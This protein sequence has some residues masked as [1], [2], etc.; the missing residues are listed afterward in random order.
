MHMNGMDGAIH[1]R[2]Q[3]I[4]TIVCKM[5]TEFTENQQKKRQLMHVSIHF[6]YANIEINSWWR[7]FSCWVP[8]SLLARKNC[9]IET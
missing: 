2:R 6:R 4:V 1:A 3:K 8:L 7:K 9:W 5:L